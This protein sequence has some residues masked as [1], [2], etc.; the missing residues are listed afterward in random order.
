[1]ADENTGDNQTA[2][3]EGG[4]SAQSGGAEKQ[5]GDP[6]RTPGKAEGEDDETAEESHNQ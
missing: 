3:Q 4:G 6:G 5:S 2:G 1:M